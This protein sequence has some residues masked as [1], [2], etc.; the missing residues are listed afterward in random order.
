[1]TEHPDAPRARR[2]EEPALRGKAVLVTAASEGLGFACARRLAEAGCRVAICGRRPDALSR[3]REAIERDLGAE[4]CAVPADLTRAD[5]IDAFFAEARRRFGAVHGLVINSGHVPYGGLGE[6]DDADWHDAFALILMSAVRLSRLAVPVM[7]EQR[8]GDIVFITSAVIR[9]PSSHLL[10]SSVMRAGVAALAKTLAR[11]LAADNIRVN[12]VAPGYFDTGR[13]R[14]RID[15]AVARDST[16]RE[17]A[18]RRIAGEVPLGRIGDA[19]ELAEL[20]TFLL[21][22]RAAYLTGAAVQIDGGQS[23]GLL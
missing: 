3:A 11:D 18:A 14:R 9:E 7:R 22:R 15:E 8:Y 17:A 23:R 21:S 16:T 13:V 6:R 1:V 19:D 12:V 5:G 10:L 4:V 2:R 20:V